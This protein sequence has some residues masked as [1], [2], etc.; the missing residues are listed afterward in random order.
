MRQDLA[1][2]GRLWVA[3]VLCLAWP[4]VASADQVTVFAAASLKTALDSLA[5]EFTAVSGHTLSLS[6]AGSSSLA[7]QIQLGAPADVFISANSAWMDVLEAE[8]LILTSSRFDMAG[9]RLVIVAPIEM[10]APLDLSRPDAL[11][12]RLLEGP[13]AMGLVAAVPAGI[14]GKQALERLGHWP[15][16]ESRVAQTDNVRAALALVASG[17][18]PLGVVY[19]SDA[20]ADPNVAVVAEIPADVHAP[21]RYPAARIDKGNA[22]GAEFLAFLRSPKAQA[23]LQTQGFLPVE[24]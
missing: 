6:L 2:R 11:A 7:R 14:Y 23:T 24:P 1:Q 17:E 9:N 4:A 16:V 5:E 18:A 20:M 10:A 19:A 3:L 13:L 15:Q 8:G 21:I 12:E 22:A